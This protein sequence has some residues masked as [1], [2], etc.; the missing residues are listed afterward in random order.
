MQFA[1]PVEVSLRSVFFFKSG[2]AGGTARDHVY[3]EPT[4]AFP[5]GYLGRN[6]RRGW[7]LWQAVK[8]DMLPIN[9]RNN[10]CG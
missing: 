4:I 10:C 1:L 5:G 2:S 8:G 9:W 3:V 7:L 6:K